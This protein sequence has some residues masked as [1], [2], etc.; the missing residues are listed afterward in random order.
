MCI[1]I[2]TFC[3]QKTHTITHEQKAKETKEEKRKTE[4]TKEEEE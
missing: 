4:E 2:Y 3:L 1:R